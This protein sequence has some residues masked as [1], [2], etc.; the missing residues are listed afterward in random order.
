RT[1]RRFIEI[2]S[3]Y[4]INALIPCLDLDVPVYARNTEFLAEC[5]VST[6]LPSPA[7]IFQSSKLRLPSFCHAN[8]IPTPR[9]IHVLDLA[10]LKLHADQFGYPLV[11]KSTVAGARTVHDANEAQVEAEELDGRWG[12][13]VLLQEPI[14]GEQFVVA[15]VMGRNH[16]ILGLATA[17]KLG[18][19]EKGKAVFGSM[20]DEPALVAHAERILDSLKW[21]GPIELEFIQAAGSKQYWLFEINC[22]FPSWILAAHWA[23]GNLP[24]VLLKEMLG[25]GRVESPT[26]RA[27]TSFV[28]DVA[29]T[30]IP[31]SKL[32]EIDRFGSTRGTP[33][34]APRPAKFAPGAIRAAVSGI[35]SLDVVNAGLGVA[36]ALTAAP[37]IGPIYGFGYGNYDS[38]LYR[39]D[40]F[41]AVYRFR[42]MSDREVVLDDLKRAHESTPFD[43]FIPCLDGEIPTFIDLKDELDRIGIETLLPAQASFDRRSKPRLFSEPLGLNDLAFEVPATVAV[44]SL[45]ELRDA[46]RDLGFPVAIKGAISF[47]FPA[48]NDIEAEAAW[49]KLRAHGEEGALVQSFVEG[50]RFAV[51]A[52]CGRNHET[53]TSLTVK[54]LRLCDRGSTWSAAQVHQPEL[55]RSFADFVRSIEWVGPVEGEFIRD[56]RTERFNL[57]E[58]NPRF[59]AWISYSAGIGM[60]HPRRAVLEATGRTPTPEEAI[61]DQIFMR[62]CEDVEVDLT[63]LASIATRGRLSY[64]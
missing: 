9:T 13:G 45:S 5:G 29:E 56:E 22:R 62:S 11:L 2:A 32:S 54:K 36:R 51:A 20:V 15:A 23:N 41:N 17:K 63:A 42:S 44:T 43:V 25:L 34:A 53:M 6:V 19:N 7:A 3:A 58:V 8:E 30:A 64:D 16:D 26:L 39:Q 4:Q 33:C 24:V 14:V 57:I 18:V 55:E 10:D 59:T 1:I 35:G 50:D 46:T 47:A 31:L 61:R 48:R 49:Y 37:E 38:G 27:G 28:R 12:G 21:R 40:L 60:N 52:V